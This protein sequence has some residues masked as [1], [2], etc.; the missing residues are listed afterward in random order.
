MKGPSR[1]TLW[2]NVGAARRIALVFIL[3]VA[4]AYV[5]SGKANTAP[6]SNAISVSIPGL[7][8]TVPSILEIP[9]FGFPFFP[10]TTVTYDRAIA[11]HFVFSASL[12]YFHEINFMAGDFFTA[13]AEIDW[14]SEKLGLNGWFVGIASA[15]EADYYSAHHFTPTYMFDH[16][17][18]SVGTRRATRH[19]FFEKAELGGTFPVGANESFAIM[20]QLAFGISF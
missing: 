16:F 17:G 8:G 7:M 5:C 9:G 10:S 4:V 3:L 15:A 20:A 12:S 13:W 6:P 2:V 19:H 14:N 11:N 1:R 18:L